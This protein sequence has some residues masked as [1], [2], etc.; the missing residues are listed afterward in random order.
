VFYRFQ[1]YRTLTGAITLGLTL[2]FIATASYA[3]SGKIDA[4]KLVSVAAAGKILDTKVTTVK[5]V[6]TSAAEPDAAS[7]CNYETGRIHGGF[8]LIAGRIRYTDAAA[9]VAYQEKT[10]S[11]DV[12][13]GMDYQPTFADIKGLGEAAY[14]VKA[15]GSFQLHVLAHGTEIVIGMDVSPKTV[16]QSKQLARIALGNLK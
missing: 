8:I 5:P 11:S 2:S 3:S 9:E 14:I 1:N 4:C 7:I 6:D 12:P 15:R 10:A 13:P 16:A